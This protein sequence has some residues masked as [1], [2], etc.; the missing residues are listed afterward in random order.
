MDKPRLWWPNGYGPQNLYK[1]HLRFEVDKQTS[2]ASEVTF[3][4]R[5]ITYAVPDSDNL[6]ISVN[7]ARVFIRGGNWGLDEAMKR[8]PR[9]RLDAQ[10]HMH[11]LAGMNMIRNW[12]GQST[13]EDFYELCDKYG[14]LLWDEFFQPNPGDGPNPADL[15]TYLANVRDKI[16]RFRNHPS[17]A[18]WCARNEG[19]PPKEIDDALRVIMRSWSRR[20]S[21]RRARPTATACSRMG[22][23]TGARPRVLRH[24]AGLLQDRDRQHVR[25]D[26]RIDQGHDAEAGLGDHHR[27]LGAAR[28]RQGSAARRHLQVH[29]GEPLRHRRQPRRLRAQSAVDELRGLPRDVRRPQRQTLPPR[30][31]RDDLDEQPRAAQLRLADLPLRSGAERLAVRSEE[32]RR[33]NT[34]PAQRSD[35]RSRG[36]QQPPQ[37]A[38]RCDGAYRPLQPRRNRGGATRYSGHSRSRCRH[39]PRRT[40]ASGHDLAGSLREAGV[41]G[42]RRQAA[43]GQL[44]LARS[45]RTSRRPHRSESTPRGEANRTREP[46]RRRRQNA[47]DGIAS[48]SIELCGAH[49]ARP[50][51]PQAFRRARPAGLR[52]RQLHLSAAE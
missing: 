9:E 7:G 43:L 34:H 3:G 30:D 29:P 10:I 36:H 51:T 41:E 11:Q 44:L 5:K 16:L 26:A 39:Q 22:R 49:G 13:G 33:A 35:R 14:L 12:V 47:G 21:T 28:F 27:R 48:Q 37:R 32:G 15:P 40:P 31:R 52:Q 1:L 24:P 17:I 25:A 19:F 50:T 20:A 38:E 6:T 42:C 23:T 45:D 2:D 4:V 18:V 46:Q 8:I